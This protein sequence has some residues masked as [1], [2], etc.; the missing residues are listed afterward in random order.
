[1]GI[2]ACYHACADYCIGHHADF[3]GPHF[4]EMTIGF[5][6]AIKGVAVFREWISSLSANTIRRS[7]PQFASALDAPAPRNEDEK[8]I[9]EMIQRAID[10]VHDTSKRLF[11]IFSVASWTC[12]L[13]GILALYCEFRH[14]SN[15]LLLLV[16]PVYVCIVWAIAKRRCKKV[17]EQLTA[18][19]V[20][21][22]VT[23]TTEQISE[24]IAKD[25][26]EFKKTAPIPTAPPNPPKK[27]N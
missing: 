14:C 3:G 13:W 8:I 17:S 6:M 15:L 9:K 27:R 20:V 12:V 18:W 7:Y 1:M 10:S 25:I 16:W 5:N 2:S 22:S 21:R 24:S 26:S 11:R 19:N 4:V 23:Q